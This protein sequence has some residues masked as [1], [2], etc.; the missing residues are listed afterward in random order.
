MKLLHTLT[1]YPPFIGGAQLHQHLLAQQLHE[2]HKVQAISFWDANRTDWLLGTTLKAHAAP[3]DYTLE[4][5]AVHRLGFSWCDKL[6]M[7]PWLPLYYPLMSAALPPISQVIARHLTP[8][9][10]TTDLIHNVR[11]GREGLTYASWQVARQQDIPF[12]FTPVHH[13]RWVGWRY[14]AYIDLYKQADAIIALT[15][16]ERQT[17][18]NLGVK[19]DKIH[20]TGVGPVLAER[21]D[22]EAFRNRHQIHGPMILFLGQHYPYKGYQQ[23]LQ[24]SQQIWQHHPDTQLVFIGPPV[25][26]SEAVFQEISDPRIHRLGTVSLQEK[27]DALAACDVLCLPSAQESFGGVYTEAWSF[28]KPVIGCKIP[29]VSDVIDDGV[30]GFL[31]AQDPE[32]I[33]ERLRYLLEHPAAA[34]QMGL[35]GQQKVESRYSWPHLARLTEQAY[36][37]L[38]SGSAEPVLGHYSV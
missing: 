19:D 29:A 16:S 38:L 21:A 8:F 22:G 13:P 7:A 34:K 36:R 4:D 28:G 31:V 35:A 26:K 3:R 30:D 5:I 2:K 33:A 1:A 27:T 10:R 9:A 25:K 6:R 37:Q 32:P 12:V 11:I 15:P 17:L 24:A 23:L 14:R 18:I 20:V